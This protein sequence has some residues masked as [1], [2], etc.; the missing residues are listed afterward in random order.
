[1]TQLREINDALTK[2]IIIG[3]LAVLQTIASILLY[4]IRKKKRE[5]KGGEELKK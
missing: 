5:N 3:L 4:L 1:M 2:E